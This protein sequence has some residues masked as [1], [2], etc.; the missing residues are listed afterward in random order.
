MGTEVTE[1]PLTVDELLEKEDISPIEQ[2]R[3]T[4]ATT[5]DVTQP[6]WTFR[7]WT[8][9]LI[10]CCAMSFVNQFFSYRKEPLVI[11]QITVQVVSLPIGRFMAATLPTR[12]FRIPGFGSKEFSF[13]PGPFNMKEH[14]LITIFANA[15]SAFGSGSAYAVG[16]ITIIKVFYWRTISFFTSWLLVIT[17][18][19]LGYGWAGLMRKF[20]VEP[21]HMWWPNTLVQ[22]SL[23]RF[24]WYIFPGYIFQ[25]LQSISWVCWAFPHSVT[26]HQLGSGFSGLG[27]GSFSLDWSTVASFLGSP[28]IT[29]FFAVVN[30]FVGYV[31]LI[32]VVIPTAYWGL[33]VFNAKTFPIFSSDLFTSS[34][35]EYDI[36][37]IVDNNFELNTDAYGQVGR[38]NLSSFFAITYGF[39][40]AAIAATL[41]HV[42]L[43]HGREIVR[44]F[45]ASSEG[46]EDIHTRLMRSYKDI[47]SWWFHVVLLVAIAASLALC[48]F[49]KKEVQLPWWGLLFAAALAF[50]FTLPISIITATTNQT[51]GLN[52][53]T[54]YLMGVI[55]PGRPIANVCF[56]T[57]G[58]ISMAQAVSFLNDFK[59]GHYMKIP[60]RSMFLVQLIGTVIAGTI[61][62]SVAW[63]LLSSVDQI[64]HQSASSNSPWTCPGDRVFFDASVIWGLVGP[65]RIFGSQGNYPALN[66]FFL[67]GILGPSL[68]YLLHRIFPNQSWI[69][70]INLPVLFGA[71]ASMPPAAPINYNSWILVGTI[72][73]Y[74]LFRY[75]KKW[76]QRYNYILSAA[77]DAGVAFMALLIHFTFGVRNVHMNWWGSNPIDTDHCLL[78]SCPTAKGVVVDGCPVF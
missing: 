18:Q 27:F 70:L 37:S 54:E 52:I 44:K 29:P 63:W 55:L 24:T 25:T 50:I 47:P 16:I 13:N 21:A 67:A 71:T 45:R 76:W 46:K 68:V 15:G 57:Y 28:L 66:W 35:Q 59:L 41:T 78:A 77:L 64:C 43:F 69:P 14:V 9:G 19:V 31:V 6:V 12:K 17:T 75:R 2:V 8:L 42:A 62:V 38:V 32:Y 49:L 7:M 20:V 60:P 40:F 72:F 11:T 53:I 58:Y 5:D 36:T 22:I 51:P 61:N 26:A 65:K 3:L 23:F 33:N 56:K 39:G 34:G 73:N 1:T 30:I 74:F 4:V 48:I 10:S